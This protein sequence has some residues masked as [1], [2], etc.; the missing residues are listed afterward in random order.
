MVD[1]SVQRL[2]EYLFSQDV[3]S[4]RIH[5]VLKFST[6]V[7]KFLPLSQCSKLVLNTLLCLIYGENWLRK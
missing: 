5:W 6:Q 1:E 3:F 4:W 7:T 2:L